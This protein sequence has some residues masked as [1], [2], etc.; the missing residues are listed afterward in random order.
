[1]ATLEQIRAMR[2]RLV[3]RKRVAQDAIRDE[4][5]LIDSAIAKIDASVVK[6]MFATS[7]VDGVIGRYVAVRDEKEVLVERQK[8]EV[9]SYNAQLKEI[10]Q[11]CMQHLAKVGAESVKATTG[12]VFTKVNVSITV[13][14]REEF[15]GW[16]VEKVAEELLATLAAQGN[17]LAFDAKAWAS[18]AKNAPTDMLEARCSKFAAEAYLESCGE[19]PP[20]VA[21]RADK[22]ISI[23]RPSAR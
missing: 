13:K 20:G 1:M 14:D 19:L 17:V 23:N 12:T 10:E 6:S 18:E 11:W 15:F 21:R 8:D 22:T 16:I 3:E 9:A 2:E 5:T 4:V 7:Q